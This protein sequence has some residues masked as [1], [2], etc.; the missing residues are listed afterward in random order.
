[1]P[2]R[3]RNFFFT[4]PFSNGQRPDENDFNDVWES[5]INY[6]DD[7]ISLDSDNNYVL[8]N[9]VRIGNTTGDN[10]GT[11]R[12]NGT[13]FEFRESGGWLPLGAGGGGVFEPIDG[14]D[15]VAY[16][17]GNVGIN[18]GTTP[19]NYKLEVRL[20][21]NSTEIS[22]VAN[23]VRLG[24]AAVFNQSSGNENRR[25][26]FSHHDHATDNN[27]ALRQES[28][29]VVNINAPVGEPIRFSIGGNDVRMEINED[30]D[31]V[32]E[33]N[34]IVNGTVTENG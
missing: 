14:S 2:Q 24:N 10:P 7:P 19:T 25:A 28:S 9:A 1:M 22:E 11:I 17:D 12:F 21:D 8:S 30:G 31:V 13:I 26:C 15:N 29:G 6:Q 5:F 33:G 3:T 23:R 16:N 27:F 32:I 20:E 4:G 18:T 34:L